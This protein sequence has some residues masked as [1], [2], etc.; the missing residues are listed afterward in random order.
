MEVIIGD[1]DTCTWIHE[2]IE[3]RS[4]CDE[5]GCQGEIY[6]RDGRALKVW[7]QESHDESVSPSSDYDP[8][9]NPLIAEGL[10][11]YLLNKIDGYFV[12]TL[13]VYECNDKHYLITEEVPGS[14]LHDVRK[15]YVRHNP[16]ILDSIAFRVAYSLYNAHGALNFVHNDLTSHSRN[17]M[18][19]KYHADEDPVNQP[20]IVDEKTYQV[21]TFGVYPTIIDF[22]ASTID[23]E[24]DSGRDAC[25]VLMIVSY[26]GKVA[27]SE[28]HEANITT[29]RTRMLE[30]EFKTGF[31][32][33]DIFKEDAFNH[34]QQSYEHIMNDIT[35]DIVRRAVDMRANLEIASKGADYR[36]ILLYT[37]ESQHSRSLVELSGL[38]DKFPAFLL[39][40][41]IN[42]KTL[43]TI[44]N[45]IIKEKY[46]DSG[47]VIGLDIDNDEFIINVIWNYDGYIQHLEA[48]G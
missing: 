21:P 47:L 4:M 23:P 1:V 5:E 19:T 46:P 3:E 29:C 41:G 10:L 30:P 9:L 36:T 14:T 39:L 20:F 31:T 8:K 18:I 34:F 17:I 12:H 15:G 44:A 32:I 42:G 16:D 48:D 22:G 37:F 25:G 24:A 43:V 38:T 45:D 13:G 11:G 35:L 6:L 33:E 7:W 26:D 40:K 2:I 28:F 27:Q